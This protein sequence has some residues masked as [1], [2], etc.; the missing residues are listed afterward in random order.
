MSQPSIT[1]RTASAAPRSPGGLSV[2]ALPLSVL[3]ASRQQR[4][5]DGL[6]EEEE[7]QEHESRNGGAGK[8]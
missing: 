1:P 3:G 7:N 6:I 2:A 8:E 4:C 5:E